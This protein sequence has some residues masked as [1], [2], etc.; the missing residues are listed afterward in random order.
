MLEWNQNL[1]VGIPEIDEQHERLVTMAGELDAAMRTDYATHTLRPKFKELL[2]LAAAHFKTEEKLMEQYGFPGLAKH[3]QD[4]GAITMQAKEI[5]EKN[6]R[7]KPLPYMMGILDFVGNWL[8]S[9]I[10]NTDREYVAYLKNS[11]G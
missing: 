5:L 9:H 7:D 11:G 1:T 2:E 8:I 6:E 3:R 4:H 10:Q